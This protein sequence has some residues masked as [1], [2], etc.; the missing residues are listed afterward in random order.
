MRTD[1]GG[2]QIEEL[3]L[4]CV[5]MGVCVLGFWGFIFKFF[6]G[7]RLQGQRV[8]AREWGDEWEQDT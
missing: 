5:C 6:G 3:V 4:V 8:E 1:L 2:M 7:S